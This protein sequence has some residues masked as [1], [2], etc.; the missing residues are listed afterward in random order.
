MAEIKPLRTKAGTALNPDATLQ[1]PLSDA[2]VA[3][4]ILQLQETVN[5]VITR[6]N[7]LITDY[8]SHVHSGV[9]VG[10]GNTEDKTTAAVTAV[11]GS[12]V[13]DTDLFTP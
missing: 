9:T 2:D 13:A 11:A 6:V 10:A 8:N 5:E 7:A 4:T 3:A 1:P 12:E